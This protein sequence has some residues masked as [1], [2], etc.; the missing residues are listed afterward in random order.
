M[1]VMGDDDT[2][3]A[4]IFPYVYKVMIIGC[5]GVGKTTLLW[6]YLHNEFKD[7]RGTIIDKENKKVSVNGRSIE[8]EIWDTA[9]KLSYS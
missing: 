8:L 2:I 3:P 7:L 6:R 5:C 4:S 9:G 1:N